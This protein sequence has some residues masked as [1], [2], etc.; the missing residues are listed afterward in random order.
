MAADLIARCL[1]DLPAAA[2]AVHSGAV[3]SSDLV[4]AAL[5]RAA[6]W[7]PRIHAFVWLDPERAR[8]LAAEA[9]RLRARGRPLG[10]LHGV[11]VAVKDIVD[12]AGIPTE[13]GTPLC[14]GR[15][16][17]R[18]AEVVTTLE[19]AGAIVLGKTVTT[20]VAFYHPGPTRNPWDPDR[21]PGGSSMGSAAAVA[22]GIVPGAVGT[23]TNGSVI[24]PAAFCGVVGF[25]P[26]YGRIP[27]TGVMPFAATLDTVGSLA[28]SVG[29]AAWLA[30]V[31]AG[32]PPDAWAPLEGGAAAETPPP[33]LA[34]APTVDAERAEAATRARFEDDVRA[35]EA[36]GARVERPPLPRD[37][38]EALPTHRTIMVFE[39]ARNF[40]PL[41]AG[42]PEA[43]SRVL[44]GLVE[45]GAKI[46]LVRYQHALRERERLIETFSRW[47]EPFDALLTL[48]T[49]G[50]APGPETTGDPRFCTRWT[51]LGAPA[52]TLP[53]GVG[54]AGLPLGLQLVGA[55]GDDRRL[56]AAAAWAETRR[57]APGA[58]AL[59]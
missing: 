45:E 56:V 34:V 42:H 23:Q 20:E 11:P 48:A 59:R 25:K 43:A 57:P 24:R 10:S 15:V 19:G 14:R 4:A 35:L 52:V 1:A 13:N 50:E 12:T 26:S 17:E 28:R 22:A 46:P 18:S 9:D 49:A 6:A 54:P 41:V 51:L 39:G 32:D 38:E 3:T 5:Q 53:T 37:L 27:T 36:V 44:R 58:P 7:E 2:R 16:P 31:M 47:M 21:T 55:P 40:G 33:R 30:A 29:S 8:R